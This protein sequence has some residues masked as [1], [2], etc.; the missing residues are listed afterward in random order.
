MTKLS[1]SSAGLIKSCTQRYYYYKV[2]QADIDIDYQDD[3]N[4]LDVGKAFHFIL[5]TNGHTDKDVS[6]LAEEAAENYY[7]S[8]R[9]KLLVIAM[10]LKYVK[11]HKESGL[12]V[13]A[14]EVPLN[15]EEYLGFADVILGN[16]ETKEWWIGDLKT[17]SMISKDTGVRLHRDTQLNLYSYF[18]DQIAE[19][20][21]LD[22]KKFAGIRYRV[23]TKSKANPR[24]NESDAAFVKR[25]FKAVDSYD[26]SVP[27]K[28]LDPKKFYKDHLDIQKLAI[29]LK[30]G[31]VKPMKNYQACFN[32]FRP[33]PYWSRCHGSNFTDKSLGISCLSTK[34]L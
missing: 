10:V 34:D 25:M 23:T 22:P 7:L 21:G 18:K 19:E 33:C 30:D 2:E 17:A 5:E 12:H 27:V 20:L 15:S 31:K 24:V 11:L 3:T 29:K 1:Y 8:T 4:A 14:C 13:L 26:Y 6:K 28:L 32:Y 16:P 9:D